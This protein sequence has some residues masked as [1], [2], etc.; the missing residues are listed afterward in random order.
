MEKIKSNAEYTALLKELNTLDPN[1]ARA[2]K[3]LDSLQKYK[4]RTSAKG[5][6]LRNPVTG[7]NVTIGRRG[8]D[9]SNTVIFD[10]K[11]GFRRPSKANSQT[12]LLGIRATINQAINEIPTRKG[13]KETGGLNQ[14]KFEPISDRRDKP[15]RNQ[16]ASAYRR[17][18]RGAFDAQPRKDGD[19]RGSGQRIDQDTWQPRDAKGRYKKYVKFNPVTQDNI[20]KRLGEQTGKRIVSQ[21]L[22]RVHPYI[23]GAMIFDDMLES[24]TGVRPSQIIT[25]GFTDTISDTL[26]EQPDINLGPI[27]PF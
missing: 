19:W 13:A 12:D 25:E 21:A 20:L 23:Q 2:K 11:G 17:A 8:F 18:T 24:I 26:K 22:G 5:T 1:S 15:G 7:V 4:P 16:R 9:R 6:T 14:Y 3:I 10:S 27:M